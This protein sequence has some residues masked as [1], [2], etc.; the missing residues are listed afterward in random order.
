MF[1]LL[2]HP[3]ALFGSY[4]H[5]KRDGSA[6]RHILE[7]PPVNRTLFFE[8]EVHE[9]VADDCLSVVPCCRDR[10]A[11]RYADFP[12]VC[13]CFEYLFVDAVTTPFIGF[14]FKSLD[15][16][17]RGKIADVRHF[18][19][20]FFV[21]HGSVRIHH[22]VVVRMIVAQV[23]N[24]F[25]FRSPHQWFTSGNHGEEVVPQL[26]LLADNSIDCTIIQFFR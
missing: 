2:E 10:D 21:D 26:S 13:H 25:S 5:V 3:F 23:Y 11:E 1:L 22:E 9:F 12:Q 24:A 7:H 8:V 16:N 18:L 19:R 14:L 6:Y 4:H 17:C 15:G 20:H